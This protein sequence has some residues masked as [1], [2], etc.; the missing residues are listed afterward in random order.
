[1]DDKLNGMRYVAFHRDFLRAKTYN[2]NENNV[3]VF[4]VYRLNGIDKE[5]EGPA[6][7]LFSNNV[8][9]KVKYPDCFRGLCFYTD[10]NP[11]LCV[12]GGIKY[13]T[14]TSW[15]FIYN[16]CG[17]MLQI[18]LFYINGMWNG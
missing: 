2:I 16:R 18:L 5:Q 9:N 14:E 3:C 11:I 17:K 4:I 1:M 13:L 7:F 8:E 12:H 10:N 6:N 15:V